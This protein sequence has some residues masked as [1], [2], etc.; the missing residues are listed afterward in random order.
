MG[1][2]TDISINKSNKYF[3]DLKFVRAI[4]SLLVVVVH[5]T[6]ANYHLHDGK[7]NWLLLFLIRLQDFL[8]LCSLL[9]ADFYYII[10]R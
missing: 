2:N 9:L 5:V 3:Y 10:R 4:A 7:L 1:G 8:H 6:A